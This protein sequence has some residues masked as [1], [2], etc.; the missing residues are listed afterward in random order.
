MTYHREPFALGRTRKLPNGH[1]PR[2]TEKLELPPIS[3]VQNPSSH[4]SPWTHPHAEPRASLSSDRLASLQLPHAYGPQPCYES[5]DGSEGSSPV[6]GP[7]YSSAATSISAFSN[8]PPGIDLQTS[9]TLTTDRAA[10]AE[11]TLPQHMVETVTYPSQHAGTHS[12]PPAG[13]SYSNAMNQHPQYLESSQ[14]YPSTG[15]SYAPH[16]VTAGGMSQYHQY[17]SQ[18]AVLQP[19]PSAYA[20]STGSYGQYPYPNGVAS[21]PVGSQSIPSSMGSQVGPAMMPLPGTAAF[22][23]L[24]SPG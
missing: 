8:P 14:S 16:S 22:L 18:P 11:Q 24:L 15:Q 10:F 12:Y 4:D 23:R 7:C 20:P 17:P 5:R 3:H 21:P 13:V 9:P 19:N 2:N 6:G 1:R